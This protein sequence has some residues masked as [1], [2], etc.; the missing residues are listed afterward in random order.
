MTVAAAGGASPL[1]PPPTASSWRPTFTPCFTVPECPDRMC[2]PVTPSAGS[3]CRLS[4]LATPTRSP[5]WFAAQDKL[6][7]LSTNSAHQVV[8]GATHQALVA[9][10]DG[11]AATTQAI[12][13][14]VSSVQNQTPLV[15]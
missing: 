7:K 3:T 15:K 4:P 1:R 11:A 8:E 14:V 13:D 9:D 5:A 12:I 10:A 6:A 2:S